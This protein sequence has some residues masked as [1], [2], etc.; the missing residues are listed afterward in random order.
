M[1]LVM[2]L[3]MTTTTT[4][5]LSLCAG[6][7]LR[8]GY[9]LGLSEGNALH[10]VQAASERNP[11]RYPGECVEQCYSR[12]TPP[13]S[14]PSTCGFHLCVCHTRSLFMLGVHFFKKIKK[15]SARYSEG[16]ELDHSDHTPLF[17]LS[18]LSQLKECCHFST[19]QNFV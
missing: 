7:V 3:M 6:R 1:L 4:V 15:L 5:T 17:L 13:S 8:T 10:R 18:H 12:T 16:M 2:M 19:I 11:H 9:L 14:P